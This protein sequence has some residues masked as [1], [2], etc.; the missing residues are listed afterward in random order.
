MADTTNT[1]EENSGSI[2]DIAKSLLVT[3]ETATQEEVQEET[4]EEPVEA[5]N[6]EEE[7]VE[8]VEAD[9]DEGQTDE[10]AKSN[11]KKKLYTV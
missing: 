11:L 4:S 10:E 9:N 2:E 5:V 8:E 6:E 1:Q 3:E 7:A